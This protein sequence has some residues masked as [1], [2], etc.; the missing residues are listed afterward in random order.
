PGA[1]NREPEIVKRTS[2]FADARFPRFPISD[3]RFPFS[4]PMSRIAALF[5]KARQEN[6]A[7][8][9]GYLTAGDPSAEATV[10][11]ARALARAGTDILELGV[12]FSDPIAD[13]PVLQR[14]AERALAA[15]TTLGQVFE[16]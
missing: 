6:R 11:M 4:D 13:G 12:P 1:G 7:A 16:M 8:F 5:V 14:S 2:A 9:I 3:F 10:A 15:G